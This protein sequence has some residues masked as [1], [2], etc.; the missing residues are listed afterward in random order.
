MMERT[1]T[2][3]LRKEFQKAPK[4]KRAKK[5]VKA[6]REFVQKHMKTK[7]VLIGPKVNLK[8]WNKGIKNPPHHV[9]VTAIKDEKENIT[10]VELFGFEFKKKEKTDE[11]KKKASGLA[12]KIQE[13]LG[14]KEDDAPK[15]E[16]STK[17]DIKEVK[18]G[19]ENVKPAEEVKVDTA[20]EG[21]NEYSTESIEEKPTDEKIVEEPAETAEEEKK[22]TPSEEQA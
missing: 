16:T 2:V 8:I 4:Y 21:D 12:G 11:K 20:S 3:P 18:K 14:K 6:L 13:K 22:T 1:Y 7:D 9:K 17:K 5:A 15:T 10:R 19:V